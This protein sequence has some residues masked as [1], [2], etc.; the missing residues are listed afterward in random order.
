M[1]GA[2]TRREI[3]QTSVAKFALI[4]ETACFPGTSSLRGSYSITPLRGL[5]CFKCSETAE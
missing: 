4:R 1:T 2:E 3:Q 5:P